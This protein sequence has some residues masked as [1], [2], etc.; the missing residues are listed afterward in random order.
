VA[1]LTIRD[2]A[3]KTNELVARLGVVET[4]GIPRHEREGFALM[5]IVAG[6]AAHFVSVEATSFPNS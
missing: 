3:V 1:G 5:L 4:L 6:G 2:T